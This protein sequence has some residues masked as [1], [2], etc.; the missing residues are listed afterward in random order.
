M[1]K[2]EI[3]ERRNAIT[4]AIVKYGTMD[5]RASIYC[6]TKHSGVVV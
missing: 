1:W 5:A 3:G 2:L 6:E 4:N